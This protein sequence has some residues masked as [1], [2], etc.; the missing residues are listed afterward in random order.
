M[1]KLT[2]NGSGWMRPGPLVDVLEGEVQLLLVA[3]HLHEEGLDLGA[4]HVLADGAV[5][6]GLVA[7][8]GFAQL[9]QVGDANLDVARR[10]R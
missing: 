8:E 4:A 9:L 1:I 6:V 10:A 5:H 2:P 7:L 3:E